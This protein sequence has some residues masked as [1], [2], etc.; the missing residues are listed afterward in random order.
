MG[1]FLIFAQMSFKNSTQAITSG[2]ISKYL[3]FFFSPMYKVHNH[4]STSYYLLF[5]SSYI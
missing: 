3:G 4:N 2:R 5:G 1:F